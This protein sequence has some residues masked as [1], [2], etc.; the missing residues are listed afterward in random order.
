MLLLG[1]LIYLAPVFGFPFIDFPLLIG[2]LFTPNPDVA[3]WLGFWLF[4][5]VGVFLF[6]PLLAFFWASLPGRNI[7]F[8]GAAVKGL[9]WGFILWILSGLLLPLLGLLN[10]I[11]GLGN[12]GLFGLNAGFMAPLGSLLGHL[13]FSLAT[14]LIAAM[15]QGI[16]PIDTLGWNGYHHADVRPAILKREERDVL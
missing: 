6:A 10:R 9:V 2:G 7:G 8:S 14:A 11:D 12:P 1:A 5:L 4:F 13:A 3:L 16:E 15:G